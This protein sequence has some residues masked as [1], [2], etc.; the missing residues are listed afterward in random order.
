MTRIKLALILGP[1]FLLCLAFLAVA[2][3]A[4]ENGRYQLHPKTVGVLLDTRTGE[5]FKFSD[6][7]WEHFAARA[8]DAIV[9]TP[10]ERLRQEVQEPEKQPAEPGEPAKK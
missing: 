2:Y 10:E 9:R 4:A 8:A 7:R 5:T 1:A 3:R 6:G